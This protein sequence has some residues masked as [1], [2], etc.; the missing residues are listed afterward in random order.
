MT[1]PM[2]AK[3]KNCSNDW[4]GSWPLPRLVPQYRNLPLVDGKKRTPVGA[5]FDDG[6]PLYGDSRRRRW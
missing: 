3:R 6:V 5:Q 2:P 4:Y 1:R